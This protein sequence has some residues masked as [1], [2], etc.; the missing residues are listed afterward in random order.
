ML[1]VQ[2]KFP[3]SVIG[4]ELNIPPEASLR[5]YSFAQSDQRFYVPVL[6]QEITLKHVSA[7][8]REQPRGL[9]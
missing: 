5:R 2:H 7:C 3:S 8:T 1:G 9:I 4:E 6:K